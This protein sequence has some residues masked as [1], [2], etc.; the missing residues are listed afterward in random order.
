M[1]N[2]MIQ[3]LI[4]IITPSFNQGQYIEQ[5][6]LSILEQDYDNVELIIIDGGSTDDTI[7]VIKKY[8]NRIAYWVSEKDE[9][10]AHAIN[11]GLAKAKGEIFNWI[12]SDDYLEPGALKAIAAAFAKDS[13]KKIICGYTHC[14]YNETGVTSHTYRM[15]FKRTVADT[16]L[17]V[18]MNQ[19]G[20]FYKMDIIRSL[21]GVNESL[22]YVF[23][24]ELWFKF[25]CK[26]GLASVGYCDALIAH[27]RLHESS[28]SVGEGFFEF[29][30]EFL[31]I[32]LFISKSSKIPLPVIS[33][34]EKDQLIE[35]YK[36]NPWEL[37]FFETE[38]WQ[39]LMT[40]KYKFLLYKDRFYNLAREGVKHHLLH[41]EGHDIKGLTALSLKL[42]LPNKIIEM[43]RKQKHKTND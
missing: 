18:E 20:S 31:N 35:K 40:D 33:Y 36:S 28:K 19:P 43:I 37:V 14:F 41:L 26:Y 10:Q 7:N 4:S 17:N 32:H 38:K 16:I 23:D 30:K 9:G 12:N 5:T 3:P 25:L 24:G 15:G 6:I 27:F 34:L 22:R 42:A 39:S 11:K 2:L 1:T 13:S 8:E 29:Y 21:G